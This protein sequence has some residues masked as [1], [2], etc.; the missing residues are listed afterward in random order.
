MCVRHGL[1]NVSGCLLQHTY[2]GPISPQ[3]CP[4]YHIYIRILYHIAR[5]P[6]SKRSG[7]K[8]ALYSIKSALHMI[9]TYEPC[10]S[11]QDALY[12]RDQMKKEPYILSK[13]TYLKNP[14]YRAGSLLFF[15]VLVLSCLLF[16]K[17]VSFEKRLFSKRVSRDQVLTREETR[18]RDEALAADRESSGG[19]SVFRVRKDISEN[20]L[21]EALNV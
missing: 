20:N 5:R 12:R 14:W 16:S 8:R 7:V 1:K 18:C 19:S 4:T 3:K 9:S 13:G 17:R 6:T 21:C 2:K 10:I 11:P 15:G